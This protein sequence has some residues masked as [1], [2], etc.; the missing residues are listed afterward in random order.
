M[1]VQPKKKHYDFDIIAVRSLTMPTGNIQPT[2]AA[3]NILNPVLV[4]F[5]PFSYIYIFLFIIEYINL[6]TN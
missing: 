4:S 5:A 2:Y 3:T 1:K 6:I